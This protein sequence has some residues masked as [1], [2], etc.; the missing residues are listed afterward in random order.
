[1]I[2]FPSLVTD[3]REIRRQTE[4]GAGEIVEQPWAIAGASSVKLKKQHTVGQDAK[5]RLSWASRPTG[6]WHVN[7]LVHSLS[8]E[9]R[10]VSACSTTLVFMEQLTAR[11]LLVLLLLRDILGKV[12]QRLALVWEGLLL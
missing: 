12:R 9:A 2:F 4:S 1:V 5:E 8:G 3:S 7:S 10:R 6:T 11:H